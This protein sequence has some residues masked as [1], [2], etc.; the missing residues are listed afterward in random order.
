MAFLPMSEK[1]PGPFMAAG[2][3]RGKSK[4][5]NVV[6]FRPLAGARPKNEK[7]YK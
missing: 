5:R 2:E 3:V 1:S 7:I 6:G 4:E